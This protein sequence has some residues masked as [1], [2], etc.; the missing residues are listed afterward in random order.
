MR[1]RSFV[2][3]TAAVLLTS[4][5]V[6]ASPAAAV[7]EPVL[8]WEVMT[9]TVYA[10]F[11]RPAIARTPDGVLH[12]VYGVKTPDGGNN[13]EHRTI[14][15]SGDLGPASLLL[16]AGWTFISSEPTLLST[17]SGLVLTFSGSGPD[18]YGGSDVYVAGSVDGGATW[19]LSRS[20]GVHA[21]TYPN[22]VAAAALADGTVITARGDSAGVHYQVGFT[23]EG[24]TP[25]DQTLPGTDLRGDLG[26]VSDGANVWAYWMSSA[27]VRA[28]QIYPTVGAL[29]SQPG[30]Y[31]H[32]S[33]V[34]AVVRPGVGPV[35]SYYA[36]G[37][38][39]EGQTLWVLN[40][41]A[42]YPIPGTQGNGH[43]DIALATDGSLWLG[44]GGPINY[45]V[46]V[47]RTSKTGFSFD[48]VQ[49][50]RVSERDDAT[51]S[52]GMGT[53]GSSTDLVFN[54]GTSVEHTRVQPTYRFT[55]SPKKWRTGQ[56][57]KVLFKVTNADGGV[58]GVKIKGPGPDCTTN[59]AGKCK[60]KFPAYATPRKV[61]K[62]AVKSGY[63]T[64]SVKLK[65]KR[66]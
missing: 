21:L 60:V 40:T 3:S 62:K 65:V 30:T 27:G 66:G 25:T 57:K 17:P 6:T 49:A 23:P 63:V 20:T 64:Q 11:T 8:D 45:G 29:L 39:T 28:Q 50:F 38:A 26:L 31:A 51:T 15:S 13:Y 1:I 5:L 7:P 33:S 18:I 4:T 55:A 9:P 36:E 46:S 32:E 52:M 34:V 41:G 61:T 44:T 10:N 53:F 59:S 16:P 42:T 2:A 48:P 12:V 56:K 19:S 14:N 35:V 58:A 47:T 22:R 54:R 43:A 24:G 37:V